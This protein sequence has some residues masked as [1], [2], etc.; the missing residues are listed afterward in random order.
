[1][2]DS[3]NHP[4][5]YAGKQIEVIDYI[6][7]TLTEEETTGFCCGNVLKYVSRWRKKGGVED[8]KKARV[9]LD[10]MIEAA[11]QEAA[12]MMKGQ[13]QA[14]EEQFPKCMV[15]GKRI[16]HVEWLA[17]KQDGT[18][19]WYDA[20]IHFDPTTG[21]VSIR[22]TRKW[23][24]YADLKRSYIETILC[25]CC[26]KHPFDKAVGAEYHE[27]LEILMGTKLCER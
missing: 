25:P 11:E 22:I 16:D 12:A 19:S 21:D 15:C 23:A 13:E 9:Y 1:M 10:W 24:A 18:E 2:S 4:S 14:S 20:P 6:R 8:L 26:G 27:P 17:S 3:V 7:D 5:H